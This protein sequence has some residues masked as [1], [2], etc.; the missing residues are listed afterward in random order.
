MTAEPLSGRGPVGAPL[1]L[2]EAPAVPV[3]N[4]P[5]ALTVLRLL[6]VP[7][8]AAVLVAAA[9]GG[10]GW[11]VAAWAVFTAACLTDVVDGRLARGRGQ[12]T[13]FG[14]FADPIA[15]KAL[16]GTAL[17]GLSLLGAVPWW[18][19]AVVLGREVAVTALRTAVLRH[20]VIPA[21]RGGKVKALSQNCAV[22]LYLLPLSG[23]A[24][25]ARVPVLA[26]AVVATVV[27]GVDYAVAAWRAA[28]AR[29]AST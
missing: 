24:A 7:V 16:V 19:T 12:C 23:V 14:A 28:R 6:S 5:N 11:L 25:S 21:S 18:V 1:T 13:D 4:L 27:T 26:L 2:V 9:R 3:V 10:D 17:V 8:F 20:G 15:D 22:A 29:T